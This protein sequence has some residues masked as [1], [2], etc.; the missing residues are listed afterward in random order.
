[1]PIRTQRL[2]KTA[3]AVL[4]TAIAAVPSYAIDTCKV[5]VDKRT[6]VILADATNVVGTLQWGTSAGN[7][8]N[9]IFN[10]GTCVVGGNAKKCQIGDPMTL[11]G[12]T[13]PAG[14]TL[15]LDDGTA[16][17]SA[18]IPGCTPSPRSTTGFVVKDSAGSVIGAVVNSDARQPIRDESGVKVRLAVFSD[19]SGFLPSGNLYFASNDCGGTPLVPPD[20]SMVRAS[21]IV[22]DSLGYYPPASGTAQSVSS[23][24]YLFGGV[25]D[26]G[27][28][29]F[30]IG[31]TTFVAPHG[32][33]ESLAPVIT[34]MG[35]P[36]SM[37]LGLFTP[38]F[39][40]EAP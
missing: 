21:V 11:A 22:S 15:Y 28:C 16:P 3:L 14:C 39:S 34:T 17:C 1:M 26:Q 12:K 13:P 7:E 9:A 5:K 35:T 20:T 31:G 24:E 29:D 40:V 27:G 32:C 25:N 4:A 37:N 30:F 8:N 23:I 10:A 38:P 6:G 19:G 2:T 36:I 33:C 18:W